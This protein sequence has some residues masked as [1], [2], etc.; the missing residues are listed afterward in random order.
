MAQRVSLPSVTT[1]LIPKAPKASIDNKI[2]TF[3]GV[4]NSGTAT[5]NV[6]YEDLDV[7]QENTLFGADSHI[8]T[9]IRNFRVV[10]EISQINAISVPV[11]SG[12]AS[13]GDLVFT[14]TA[15]A[16]GSF[17]VRIG[18][19]DN[20][21]TVTV[22]IGDTAADVMTALETAINAI[23]NVQVTAAYTSSIALTANW[24]GAIGND[25]PIMVEGSATGLSYTITAMA[26]GTGTIDTSTAQGLVTYRT[27]VVIPDTFDLSDWVTLQDNRFN[28]TNNVKD[29]RV[30][31]AMTDTKANLVTAGNLYNSENLVI[32]GDKPVA[33]DSKKGSAIFAM[34]EAR[35]SQFA[36]LRARLLETDANV[37]DIVVTTEP[38]ES[39][40]GPAHNSLPYFNTP[41]QFPVMG[42]G[43]GFTEAEVS[44]LKD[45]GVAVM[46]NNDANNTVLVG[47][48]VTT[49]KTNAVGQN[50]T[51]YK[52]INYVDTASAAREYIWNSLKIDYVQKRLTSGTGVSGRSFATVGGVRADMTKYY[53]TLTGNTY[54]L[55][56]GG[57]IDELGV[58]WSDLYKDNLTV[59]FDIQAGKITITSI[60]PL[61]TQVRSIIAPL[62]IE[63][64]PSEI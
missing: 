5:D 23:A 48:V 3:I 28:I 57:Y 58:N 18:E 13:A 4:Q 47:E 32:F 50:D 36:G 2:T 9:M 42:T 37:A 33:T 64:N 52:Y 25:I 34:P 17:T 8:A 56:Q 59:T 12:S 45:A 41:T 6:L 39:I 62:N 20:D 11:S 30:F 19:Y 15:T 27:D 16:A 51:T 49:Y 61:V 43:E 63:F 55:L 44:D 22:A 53:T 31:T 46:G 14:G 40:G 26:G 24:D 35:A 1:N 60:L 54:C 7:L 38:L 29:G 21:A 10:N